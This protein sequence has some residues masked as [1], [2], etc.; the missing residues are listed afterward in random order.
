MKDIYVANRRSKKESLLKKF[1]DSEIVDI[2]SKADFPWVKFSPFFPHGDIPVPNSPGVF[3]K[4]VEGIWQ[5][6][7]VFENFDVD[8][9]K[10]END[11]MKGI[12]R[13]VRKYG[14][15]LGHRDGIEGKDLLGY[16][17]A[18]RKNIYTIV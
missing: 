12:K 18:R 9:S 16:E 6:L 15:V 17:L 7:K 4:S 14:V 1:G 13:T 5:A 2:T 3:G 11:S 8:L 10:L